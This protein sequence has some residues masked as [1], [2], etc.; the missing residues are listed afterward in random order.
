MAAGNKKKKDDGDSLSINLTPM[1]D[2]VFQL[3]IFFLCATKF[4]D[5][6]GILK[7]WL[8]RNKGQQI[9]IP[10]ID[11]FSVRLV[12]RMEGSDITCQYEDVS[13]PTGFQYFTSG[14]VYDAQ[15][16][17]D[18]T[19]PRWDEVEAYLARA[20][21]E[22]AKRGTGQE[23][24]PVILDFSGDVPWK[25]VVEILNICAGL[26]ITNLQIAAPELADDFG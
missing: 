8:P 11:P 20:R 4:P 16:R 10:E 26:Q 12:L 22:Y 6:E 15:T 25:H 3:L 23:G 9:T 17:Q 5:P 18:E 13:S 2:V 1:I 19:V 24:L 7:S 14:Q 21:D